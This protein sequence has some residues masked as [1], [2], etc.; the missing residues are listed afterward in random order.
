MAITLVDSHK[1]KVSVIHGEEAEIDETYQYFC[2][3]FDSRLKFGSTQWT[4]K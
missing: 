4:V 2:T 1:P 3:V